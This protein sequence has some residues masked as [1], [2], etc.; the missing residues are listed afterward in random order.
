MKPTYEGRLGF[1]AIDSADGSK[2]VHDGTDWVPWYAAGL[3][4]NI[5]YAST[6]ANYTIQINDHVLEVTDNTVDITLPTALAAFSREYIIKN[7][8]SGV[9]TLYTASTETIDGSTTQTL[10]QYDSITVVSNNINWIII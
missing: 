10:N 3:P 7:S 9:V 5:T 1:T 6:D 8:G 2:W 4:G